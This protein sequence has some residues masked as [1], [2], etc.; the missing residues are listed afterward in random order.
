MNYCA[1][2]SAAPAPGGRQQPRPRRTQRRVTHNEKRYHSGT[3]LS[4]P[5]A[6]GFCTVL[7]SYRNI[8]KHSLLI[9]NKRMTWRRHQHANRWPSLSSV[10]SLCGSSLWV[11]T[12]DAK[13]L[14][15]VNKR[16]G[17]FEKGSE[18]WRTEV[19]SV[20]YCDIHAPHSCMCRLFQLPGSVGSTL[21]TETVNSN[22]SPHVWT[23]DKIHTVQL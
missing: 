5:P 10:S 12:V 23:E 8:W 7:T 20:I 18:W 1:C 15:Q 16:N 14:S 13:E 6:S 17:S 4:I 19:Q 3:S 11:V 22:I 2:C 21:E 9:V